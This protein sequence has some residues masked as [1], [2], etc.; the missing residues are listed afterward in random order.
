M[1]LHLT[2]EKWEILDLQKHWCDDKHFYDAISQGFHMSRSGPGF[3]SKIS[4][5][6]PWDLWFSSLLM[7]KMGTRKG[8][9]HFSPFHNSEHCWRTIWAQ[10]F[11]T[12]GNG[13]VS[14]YKSLHSRRPAMSNLGDSHERVVASGCV[15]ENAPEWQYTCKSCHF[16]S[17][18]CWIEW[19]GRGQILIY[20]KWWIT[21]ARESLDLQHICP[22]PDHSKHWHGTQKHWV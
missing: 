15:A 6:F 19:Q 14:S 5:E 9:T 18:W 12:T 21:R 3:Q 2:P 17:E 11:G 20:D 22:S 10:Y 4:W 7:E 8:W 13:E 16:V 1:F